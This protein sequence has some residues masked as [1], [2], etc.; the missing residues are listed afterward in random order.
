MYLSETKGEEQ[1]LLSSITNDPKA[2]SYK[3]RS[4]SYC[5]LDCWPLNQRNESFALNC[6][7]IVSKENDGKGFVNL[8]GSRDDKIRYFQ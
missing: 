7:G 8:S 5:K 2:L 6:F 4:Y 3:A 1:T